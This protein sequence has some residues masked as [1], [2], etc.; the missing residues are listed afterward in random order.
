VFSDQSAIV[1]AVRSDEVA[2]FI[3][4]VGEHSY[5]FSHQRLREVF[6]E[7]I[8]P[9]KERERLH[10]RLV[11]Y[12]KVWWADRRQPLAEYLRRFWLLH[13]AEVGE[14]DLIR[15][16][17]SAIVPTSDGRGAEQLDTFNVRC[18]FVS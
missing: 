18:Y 14:W 11:D 1:D 2:R 13:C 3:I 12:S 15:E 4:T 8:Y 6:L 16:V 9:P 7:Q 5:V 10:R 17:V